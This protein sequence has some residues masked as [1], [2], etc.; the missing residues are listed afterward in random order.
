MFGGVLTGMKDRER[1][2]ENRGETG[3]NKQ[4]GS[5]AALRLG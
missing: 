1:R 3:R 4:L 5:L 2:P